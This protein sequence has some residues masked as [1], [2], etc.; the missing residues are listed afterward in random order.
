MIHSIPNTDR[1]VAHWSL[2]SRW[3]E[4][5]SQDAAAIL[6]GVLGLCGLGNDIPELRMSRE[7]L[8]EYERRSAKQPDI[9]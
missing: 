9:L 2:T 5:L 6:G 8:E 3:L 7:W 4:W 1:V